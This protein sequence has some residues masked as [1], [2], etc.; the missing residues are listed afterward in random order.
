M[1]T[2]PLASAAQAPSSLRFRSAFTL[3]AQDVVASGM[4]VMATERPQLAH[5]SAHTH[6]AE[7]QKFALALEQLPELA[8]I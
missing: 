1:P 3:Q 5:L 4:P 6:S 8:R 7:R 2:R